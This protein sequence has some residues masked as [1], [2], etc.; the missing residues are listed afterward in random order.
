MICPALTS[1]FSGNDVTSN[2]AARFKALDEDCNKD[3]SYICR[4]VFY[5]IQNV[6]IC[7]QEHSLS[8][9]AEHF[10]FFVFFSSYIFFNAYVA[11]S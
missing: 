5:P 7:K 6:M 10:S 9:R 4:N 2:N 8:Q 1:C 3:A 11:H